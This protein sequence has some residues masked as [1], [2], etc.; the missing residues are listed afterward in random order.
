VAG[1]PV[2]SDAVCQTAPPEPED[3]EVTF[4][5]EQWARLEAIFPRGVCDRSAP[6]VA[7]GARFAGPWQCFGSTP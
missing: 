4:N 1:G 2:A 3:Y 7:A 5:A 6:G